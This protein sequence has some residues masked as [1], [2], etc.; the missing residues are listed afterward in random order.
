MA[1]RENKT[2]PRLNTLISLLKDTSRENEVK[3]W[4]DIAER[5]EGSSC[6]YAEV[7]VSK[8]CRYASAGETI[9]VP[10]KVLGSG[11]LDVAVH[12]AALNFSASAHQKIL[13]AEGHCMTIEELIRNNPKGSRVR[14][15]R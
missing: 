10:G 2:N 5:L 15:L 9:L 11:V 8:I 6:R 4:R 14:I 12:V 1:K 13:G 3:I 7:N